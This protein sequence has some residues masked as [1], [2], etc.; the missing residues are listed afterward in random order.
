MA[1]S[2]VAKKSSAKPAKA[3]KPAKKPASKPAAK[4]TKKPPAATKPAASKKPAAPAK[5]D[6]PKGAKQDS[7]KS[8]AL[9]A[10]T[11]KV[12][13]KKVD[14]KKAAGK[15]SGKAPAKPAEPKKL[16][17]TK[18]PVAAP[19]AGAGGAGGA[20]DKNKPKGITVVEKPAGPRGSMSPKGP[21][22]KTEMPN[23]G[24]LIAPGKKPPKPLIASGWDAPQNAKAAID[25]LTLRGKTHLAK[26]DL[27]HFRAILLR[28]RGELIGDINTMEGQVLKDMSGSLSNTPQHV[29]EQGSDAYEQALSL[30]I[31]EIDRDLIREIDEALQ[32]IEDG[33]Y[34]LC[35]VTGKEIKRERLDELPWTRYSIEAAREREK[36]QFF[37]PRN[38]EAR[39]GGGGGGAPA[40]GD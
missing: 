36:R 20:G 14:G 23:F 13:S 3:A 34:G 1:K 31:A 21:K 33:S 26:K 24:P 30:D 40:S 9:K 38:A 19:A 32:R 7:K 39:G 16:E 28:K 15:A 11:K 4:P 27:E 37:V 18:S 22:P 29:A 8:V 5:S 2:K 25:P 10:G 17:Q 6:S 12:E 35:Q